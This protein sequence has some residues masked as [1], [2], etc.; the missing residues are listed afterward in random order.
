M[1]GQG[2]QPVVEGPVQRDERV[3]VLL[4]AGS[5]D[6]EHAVREVV[7]LGDVGGGG[8][9]DGE[10]GE[11]RLEGGAQVEDALELGDGPGGDAGAAVGHDLDQALG[12]EPGQRL[13]DRGAADAQPLGELD[14]AQPG[15]GREL[16]RPGS[17]RAAPASARSAD[18]RDRVTRH[19]PW[20]IV[21]KPRADR[22]Q[23]A[24]GRRKFRVT[25]YKRGPAWRIC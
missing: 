9:R 12:G 8:V 19:T 14:L 15:P 11:L 22:F 5:A 3:E 24:T 18:V 10:A 20:Q 4:R 6:L 25:A 17:G 16:A 2:D 13:A 7:E 21:C 23:E 1:G